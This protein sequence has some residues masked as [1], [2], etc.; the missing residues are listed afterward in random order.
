M[1]RYRKCFPSGRK[2]GQRCEV[3]AGSTLVMGTGVPP[4][5]LTRTIGD[6]A[7]GANKIVPPGAQVPPRPKGASQ[8]ANGDPPLRSIVF[9]LAPA[10]K[11]TD[12]LSGDQKGKVAP[13]VLASMCASGA[14]K[15]RTQIMFLPS[16]PAAT[17]AID[18]PSGDKT[19]GPANSPTRIRA[20]FAGGFRLA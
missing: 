11:P 10:K 2:N 20:A 15:G 4:L 9:N 6:C 16:E 1:N 19:G 7:S 18:V 13:S 17:R 3:C 5:A 8:T 12:R 14:F